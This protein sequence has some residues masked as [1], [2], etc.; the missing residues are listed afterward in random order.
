MEQ[1]LCQGGREAFRQLSR[2]LSDP[3]YEQLASL[4]KAL[5]DTRRQQHEQAAVSSQTLE[6]LQNDLARLRQMTG[7]LEEG[8]DDV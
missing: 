5:E 1:C 2:T 6:E 8:S 7:R 3:L 4:R